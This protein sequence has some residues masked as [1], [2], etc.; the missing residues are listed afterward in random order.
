MREPR[1]NLQRLLI[2]KSWTLFLD[3]DGVINRKIE[4]G[5][6]TK[7]EEFEILPGVIEA[8]RILR[9][10]FGRII[11]VTN[12]RGIARGFMTE[13]DLFSIHEHMLNV[14]EKHSI[15]IDRIYFCPHDEKDNCNCRKPKTGMIQQAIKDFRDIDLKKS[16]MVGDS[17]TDIL[18]AKNMNII[19]VFIRYNN[20][21]SHI[22]ADFYF[23]SLLEF[24]LAIRDCSLCSF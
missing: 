7:I 22:D 15:F 1:R 24:A 16:I 4:N 10:V 14:F 3:R 18:T 5:Y 11:I 17:H 2:D 8:L 19:S 23:D 6:V 9:S 12:Q 13:K 20:N 21:Y